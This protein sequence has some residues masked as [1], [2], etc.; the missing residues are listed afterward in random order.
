M[1]YL[2]VVLALCLALTIPAI[3]HSSLSTNAILINDPTPPNGEVQLY[4][5]PLSEKKL[6]VALANLQYQRTTISLKSLDG[7][8]TYYQ[9]V[10]NKHNGYRRC[11]NLRELAYGKYM[12][13]VEKGKESH[14]QVIVLSKDNGMLLSAVK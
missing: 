9:D 14:R 2:S 13:V 4:V 12:L 8:I 10:V 7:T 3:A 6:D 1:K 5:T 11:L